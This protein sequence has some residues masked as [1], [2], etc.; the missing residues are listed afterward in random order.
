MDMQSLW[1]RLPVVALAAAKTTTPRTVAAAGLNRRLT[2]ANIPRVAK[3]TSFQLPNSSRESSM[4]S[5]SPS[6][7]VA[8]SDPVS[9]PPIKATPELGLLSL[10]IVLS[11]VHMIYYAHIYIIL[12]IPFRPIGSTGFA[13][14]ICF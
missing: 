11:T 9:P 2:T 4:P 10:L 12:T 13:I 3:T 1:C 8:V 6:Y 14:P 5:S 7:T